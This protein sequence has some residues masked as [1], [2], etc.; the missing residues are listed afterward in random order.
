MKDVF[1]LIEI[2]QEFEERITVALEI[3]DEE[4]LRR[5][6]T[7]NEHQDVFRATNG[8]QNKNPCYKNVLLLRIK[9]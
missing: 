9:T 3:I 6:R 7:E 1:Y 5:T 2:S 8:N 4:M